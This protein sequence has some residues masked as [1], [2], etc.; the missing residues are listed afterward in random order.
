MPKYNFRPKNDYATGCLVLDVK[1]E[2]AA[3]AFAS[4]GP[5]KF[6]IEPNEENYLAEHNDGSVGY[7]QDGDGWFDDENNSLDDVQFR[8]DPAARNPT[9]RVWV[10]GIRYI[11]AP[12]FELDGVWYC[13]GKGL[14]GEWPTRE[15][16]M[17]AIGATLCE[18]MT[19]G[20]D[21]CLVEK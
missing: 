15:A 5:I 11:R 17:A 20:L 12:L 4:S 21:V 2:D 8:P 1:D 7:N 16:A 10:R 9:Y 6:D 14:E 19:T 18:N 13:K 3:L